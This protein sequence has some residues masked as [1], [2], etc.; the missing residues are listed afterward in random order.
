MFGR[1]TITLGIGPHSSLAY[2]VITLWVKNMGSLFG[3]PFA[4]MKLHVCVMH[5]HLF[6]FNT[7]I[8]RVFIIA[9]CAVNKI[10]LIYHYGRPA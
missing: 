1:A 2:F 10:M 6:S 4:R 7:C 9:V 5:V 3:P 8:Y